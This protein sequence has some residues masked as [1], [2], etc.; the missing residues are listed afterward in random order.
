MKS[1]ELPAQFT[2]NVVKTVHANDLDTFGEVLSEQLKRNSTFKYK[3]PDVDD[4]VRKPLL[5]SMMSW[6]KSRLEIE[7]KEVTDA[8]AITA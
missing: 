8:A 3:I 4:D 6:F 1:S 7:T 5:I 2:E